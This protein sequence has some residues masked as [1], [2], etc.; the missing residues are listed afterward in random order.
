MVEV[1]QQ[2]PAINQKA[3][4]QLNTLK[5]NIIR[6][7]TRHAPLLPPDT[8]TTK[9]QLVRG[10]NNKGFPYL[11]LDIPQKFSKTEMFTYRTLFWWGHY[12][13]FSLILK[14]EKLPDYLHNLLALR[15]S[16]AWANVYVATAST[17]WEWEQNETNFLNVSRA[18]DEE[19]QQAIHTIQYIKL[20]RFHSMQ[21]E[22]F[23]DLDWTQAGMDSW[24]LLSSIAYIQD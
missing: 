9:G 2:K 7:L 11:S 5:D 16:S 12:L 10:E 15:G 20:C 24:Q 6:E 13:G 1:F 18:T 14:G 21:D 22:N 4:N 23:C 19:I 8:D 3:E 17:P